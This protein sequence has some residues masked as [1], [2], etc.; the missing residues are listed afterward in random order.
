MGCVGFGDATAFWKGIGTMQAMWFQI[1]RGFT[2]EQWSL[3]MSD[4]R[5]GVVA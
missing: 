4:S 1:R 3:V 5:G 2:I